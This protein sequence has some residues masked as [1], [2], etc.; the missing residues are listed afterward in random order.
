MWAVVLL[1]WLVVPIINGYLYEV[2]KSKLDIP[3]KEYCCCYKIC[4]I[5]V[6]CPCSLSDLKTKY[7]L[8][9]I[10]YPVILF[11]IP[12]W[13]SK[14][15]QRLFINRQKK[16]KELETVENDVKKLLDS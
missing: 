8:L 2:E 16:L 13:L 6:S 7:L 10:F 3:Y 4:R 11:Q 1:P 5:H 14:Y 15:G 12:I 9:T